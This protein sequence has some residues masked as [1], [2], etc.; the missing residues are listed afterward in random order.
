MTSINKTLAEIDRLQKEIDAFS[1]LPK[2]VLKQVKEYYRIGLT[3]S[4]NALEG[5]SLTESETKIVLEEGLTIGGKPMRD[6]YEALGHSE[7][8]DEMQRLARHHDF[9]EADI[10]KL[11]KFFYQR[12]DKKTAGKYRTVRVF[13]TGS[14]HAF[15]APE[16]VP[17]LMKQFVEGLETVRK[18]L[19]PVEYAAL[20]HKDFVFIH[21]FIDGNGRI[22][23]LLM[24][25]S[26]LQARLEIAIIPPAL[27]AE[28]IRTLEKAHTDDK[29]FRQFIADRVLE[30]QKD[31]LRLLRG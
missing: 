29:P 16:K 23:R 13:I 26:L 22:A 27:R 2:M 28:Y 24:N 19:H 8:Y 20:V 18:R 14:H 1:P 30:T 9:S 15:P 12:I 25:L 11:H 31:Y 4:S 17:G 6:H 5:N 3:Y 10:L 7:A 21:P